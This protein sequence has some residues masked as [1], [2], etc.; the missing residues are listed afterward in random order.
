VLTQWI[1]GAAESLGL[2]VQSTSIPGVA[3]RTGATTYY[4]EIWPQ[5]LAADAPRPLLA[6]LPGIGDVDLMLA[7][8]LME[9]GRTVMAGFVTPDRT[10][11]IASTA[12]AHVM[13]EKI[14]MGDGRHDSARLIEA[15]AQRSRAHIL[16]DM[17]EIARRAGAMINAVMLGAMA[18]A[19]ALPIPPEAFE[20]AITRDGKAVDSNLRGFRAGLDAVRQGATH[21]TIASAPDDAAPSAE[22]Q[23]A[24]AALPAAARATAQQG[25]ERLIR[26][27]SPAYAHLYL[28]RLKP[29]AAA[30]Q[31]AGG[32]GRLTA[33]TA[34][35]LALR[36]SYEDV[37]KVAAAKIDPGRLPRIAAEIGAQPNE[38]VRLAE[39]LKPGIEEL[40]SILPPKLAHRILAA[41]E[42][43]GLTGR[44]HWG[45]TIQSTSVAG[46]LCLRLVAALR[47]LRPRS[48]R[49]GE[50]QREI[51][52]WLALVAQA[53]ESSPDLALEI[54][55]CAGLL[56]GYGDTLQRGRASYQRI[57]SDLFAPVLAGQMP[58]TLAV[59]A[60][61][62]ARA[63]ALADPEGEGLARCLAEIRS[64]A[65]AAIAAE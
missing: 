36:M 35:Q 60:I 34:R 15:L 42:R 37:V 16:I 45:M 65:S 2:P 48:H 24:I 33:E 46:F 30:E 14:A 54:V 7:S 59:D 41:A 38:P 27:Q 31:R 39:F 61:A 55:E 29:I 62:S 17:A 13:D 9:A 56:K 64:R 40:C 51:E 18:G 32:S 11:A 26:Y 10:L 49:F 6:L 50:T 57:E 1:V 8:E 5:P 3:Q 52:A 63:A 20:A 21:P 19:N 28:D 22:F 4:I 58:V 12:R 53:A 25:V 44:L 23:H 43:R 47:R